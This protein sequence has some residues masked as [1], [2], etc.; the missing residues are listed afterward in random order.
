MTVT[1][2]G[3]VVEN[4]VVLKDVVTILQKEFCCYRY[5][6]VWD[7]LMEKE[8]IINHKKVYQLMKLHNLL[9]NRK[10]DPQ[11]FRD[12]LYV[13]K[14]SKQKNRLNNYVWTSITSISMEPKGV[15]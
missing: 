5:K 1:Q 10:L 9:F 2:D 12:S 6:N 8:Y 11:G 4:I 7:E 14:R 13:L 15:L 3:E